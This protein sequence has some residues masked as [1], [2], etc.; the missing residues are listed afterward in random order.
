MKPGSLI[1]DRL[2]LNTRENI[3]GLHRLLRKIAS[4][5]RNYRTLTVEGNYYFNLPEQVAPESP[6][7][8]VIFDSDSAKPLYVG[9]ANNLNRRLNSRQGSLD[10]FANSQRKADAERNFIKRFYTIGLL[11]NLK[12]LL[13][14]EGE[15]C[16]AFKLP[17]PLSTVDHINIEK[18]ISLF[19]W[20][21]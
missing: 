16:Q 15:V 2:D 18:F 7:W 8:Y 13:I 19:R 14:S 11:K 10:N 9:E 1:C 3:D 21:L 6:G 17:F 5:K 20:Q 12:V 4:D